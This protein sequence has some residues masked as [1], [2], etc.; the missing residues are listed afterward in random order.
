MSDLK[1]VY[2]VARI[3]VKE[4]SLLTDQDIS[5]MA[6]MKSEEEVLS[7]LSEKGWG[8]GGSGKQNAEE[9]LSSEEEKIN[10]LIEE[11]KV[12][13][14][15]FSV[16]SYP[17]LYHNLKA[18]IKDLCTQDHPGHLC[19][20]IE[21]FGEKELTDIIKNKR[22]EDLPEHMRE[23]ADKAYDILLK[24]GDGQKCDVVIDRACLTAMRNAGKAS[25]S[26]LLK[27]YVE[28]AAAVADIKIAVRAQ[29]TGKSLDF[30][31]EA[32]APCSAFDIQ[33]LAAAAVSG[34]DELMDFLEKSGYG[35]AA[36]AVK[37]SPYVFE[38]WCDD[39]VIDSIRPQKMNSVSEGPILAYYLAR[40]NEI[41]TARI[42][43][44]A[45]A[46]GFSE[47]SIR[48]RLRKMYG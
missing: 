33:K 7:W 2:A 6:G 10:S 9:M 40:E 47:E 38:K 19:Y 44:T 35:E 3:R 46:N 25:G 41:K 27:D 22:Y 17:K 30:L 45:K 32:L 34:E 48:E 13:P 4:K 15:I 29:K 42:I 16:L 18:V 21:G 12:D 23:A 11:L 26:R 14:K 28:S 1:F 43:L 5:L 24:T 31:K 39:R 20:D 8:D 37:E 36:E